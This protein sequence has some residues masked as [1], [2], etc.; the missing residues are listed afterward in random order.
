MSINELTKKQ[1]IQRLRMYKLRQYILCD[2]FTK[3]YFN[4][5]RKPV[6]YSLLTI[7]DEVLPFFQKK[8]IPYD[9][10]LIILSY[11]L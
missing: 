5:F 2:H 6:L 3:K 11:L 8:N 4:Y 1:M 9:I 7:Q 10:E